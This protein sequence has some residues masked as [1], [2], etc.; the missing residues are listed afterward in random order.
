MPEGDTVYKIAG[1]LRERILALPLAAGSTARGASVPVS[2]CVAF[3]LAGRRIVEIT[4]HGKHLFLRFNDGAV[5]RS[6]LG[7]HGSW[8]RYPEGA[9]WRKASRRASIELHAAGQVYVCFDAEEIEWLGA[10]SLRQRQIA[11]RLGPDLLAPAVDLDAIAARARQILAPDALAV[12]L[13]LDQRPSRPAL[14]ALRNR[15]PSPADG[16]RLAID[17]VVP[18]LPAISLRA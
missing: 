7:M 3:D 17:L 2:T 6:H 13:L 18:Y 15:D 14:P 12:D 8:H 1:Y 9:P 5:L 16:R 11:S 4:T 10:G